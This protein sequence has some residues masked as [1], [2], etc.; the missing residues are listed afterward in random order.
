MRS[1]KHT[2]PRVALAFPA[3][4][5]HLHR[6]LQ[7][8]KEYV[9]THTNWSLIVNTEATN[10]SFKSL[11]NWKGEGAIGV[12]LSQDDLKQARRLR[13][14]LVSMSIAPPQAG[15]HYVRADH[16]KIGLYAGEHLRSCGFEHFAFYGIIDTPYAE[17]RLRG[18]SE[19]IAPHVCEVLMSDTNL[20]DKF[21]LCDVS[22]ELRNWLRR[23]PKPLGLF[24][25]ND[26]RA[27][28]VADT[29]MELGFKVPDE[30]AIVGV[31]NNEVMCRFASPTLTSIP[32]NRTQIGYK[33][34]E[35]L[36][37]LMNGMDIP[38]DTVVQPGEIVCGEST[39]IG[40]FSNPHV[41]RAYRFV[42][43]HIHEAFGAE[44]L[45]RYLGITRRR[46]E[47]CVKAATHQTPYEFI[48]ALKVEHARQMLGN[49]NT[50][51][52]QIAKSC[53][54]RDSGHL[55]KIFVKFTDQTPSAYRKQLLADTDQNPK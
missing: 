30:V 23:M 3:G 34:A 33:A 45:A 25:A 52:H 42:R 20:Q 26:A 46:L 13:M 10:I 44:E 31:D 35:V 29:C 36:D 32:C 5:A 53:G 8:I 48:C 6:T 50:S 49:K 41:T 22:D 15:I 2:N 47:Q 28:I 7:G 14:P 39:D 21:I 18:F 51:I 1:P 11:Q 43:E 17:E 37:A 40:I 12:I 16:W 9:R 54:L 19:V 38:I 27:R 4:L 55:R 24:A